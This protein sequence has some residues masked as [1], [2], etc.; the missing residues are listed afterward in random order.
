MSMTEHLDLKGT[1]LLL[2]ALAG[3]CSSAPK[4]AAVAPAEIPALVDQTE[5]EPRAGA[6]SV[7]PARVA[8][9]A[10]FRPLSRGPAR[11][12][13]PDLADCRARELLERLQI[14]ALRD[15]LKLGTSE[16]VDPAAAARVGRLRRAERMV[17]G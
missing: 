10:P 4:P 15:G 7:R 8:C 17:Q 11:L 5:P 9:A 6:L 3:A 1:A 12:I 2:T 13:P 16:R 14:G